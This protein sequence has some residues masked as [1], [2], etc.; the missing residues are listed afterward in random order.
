MRFRVVLF[1]LGVSILAG[2]SSQPPTDVGE[3]LVIQD[4]GSSKRFVEYLEINKVQQSSCTKQDSAWWCRFDIYF[5]PKDAQVV[6][7]GTY[8]IKL[9]QDDG[10]WRIRAWDYLQGDNLADAADKAEFRRGYAKFQRIKEAL[11]APLQ[12]VKK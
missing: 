8:A 6:K 4:I 5:R 9:A 10:A 1:G 11:K 12:P 2:C 7:I 3:Q